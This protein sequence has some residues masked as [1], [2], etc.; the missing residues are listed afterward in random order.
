MIYYFNVKNIIIE[1]CYL[2]WWW[3]ASL[4]ST[5]EQNWKGPGGDL[6]AIPPPLIPSSV[7]TSQ[8][9][10]L[11]C[12][13]SLFYGIIA[14][15]CWEWLQNAGEMPISHN[16]EGFKA[17]NLSLSL[18]ISINQWCGYLSIKPLANACAF[19]PR[20]HTLEQNWN[21]SGKRIALVVI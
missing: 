8:G 7:W 17:S 19:W 1:M 4:W 15:P 20:S 3:T 9:W 5:L 2:R 11:L 13:R 6:A 18:E 14:Y 21:G 12:I 10:G 16:L